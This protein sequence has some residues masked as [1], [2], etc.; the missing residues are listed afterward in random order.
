MSEKHTDAQKEYQRLVALKSSGTYVPPAKLRT[1]LAQINV[2]KDS[3]EY[4]KLQWEALRKSISGLVNKVS[5]SNIKTIVVDLFKLNLQRGRAIFV[6]A[7]LR[8]QIASPTMTR[9]YAALVAIV[10]SKIPEIGELMLARLILQFRSGYKRKDKQQVLATTTLIAHL[11]NYRVSHEIVALQVLHFLLESSSDDAV[12]ISVNL[13]TEVGATLTETSSRACGVILERFR[14]VLQEGMVNKRVQHLIQVLFQERREEFKDHPS[15]VKELDLVEEED[16]TTHLVGLDD[17]LDANAGLDEYKFDADYEENEKKY[18]RLKHDILGSDDED[19]QS[20]SESG[21]ESDSESGSA[22][23]S[24]S[25]SESDEDKDDKVKMEITDLTAADL[26]NFQKMVYLTIM[27]SMSHEEVVHKLLKLKP[28]DENRKEYMMVDMVAK[29]CSQEKTYSKY[30]GLI[31]ENLARLGKRWDLAFRE[32]FQE[33]YGNAHRLE[34]NPL[35]N[36][37]M[38]WGHMFASDTV[39]WEALACVKITDEDTTSA[40]RIFLKFMFEKMRQELGLEKML[41]RIKE[42]YIRPFLKGCFYPEKEDDLRYSIN[43]FTAIK[44]GALTED[45]RETLNNLPE[46]IEETESRGRSRSRSGSFTG[47]NSSYSHSSSR[48]GSYSRSR[49]ASYS[50]SP[51]PRPKKS[52]SGSRSGSRSTSRSRSYSRSRSP[53][54]RRPELPPHLRDQ[55]DA[56]EEYSRNRERSPPRR[57][58]SKSGRGRGNFNPRAR[59]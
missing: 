17:E 26:A 25:E 15:V 10:N 5:A 48:S 30:Y 8:A 27:S 29:C 6:R 43:F 41:V 38:F 23:E 22:S 55:K 54:S 52:R 7:I 45:M 2:S 13:M 56:F 49:S 24:E 37:S 32:C 21:S 14:V 53:T 40:G 46:A 33:Y 35:R 19:D 18:N 36:V 42:P 20:G 3:E 9:V 16:Q 1:V 44:L 11:V 59:R 34:N 31:G 28:L 47:S 51:S 50:R 4:Q 39:G 58:F 12:E 57:N